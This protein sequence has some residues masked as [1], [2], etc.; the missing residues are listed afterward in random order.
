[1]TIEEGNRMIEENFGLLGACVKRLKQ[2]KY[3]F[4]PI[5][6]LWG[7]VDLAAVKAARAFD[8]AKG[9]FSTLLF[10]MAEYDAY[11]AFYRDPRLQKNAATVFSIESICLI[12]D[13][14][15]ECEYKDALIDYWTD[16]EEEALVNVR[17]ERADLA[18]PREAKMIRKRLEGYKLHEIGAACGISQERVRQ[19]I[20]KWY[21]EYKKQ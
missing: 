16:V 3:R 19:L 7:V 20:K 10:R 15:V 13:N 8:P 4:V 17:Q 1:M 11:R 6:D 14:D 18:A 12:L 9:D 5:D 2:T 21:Q